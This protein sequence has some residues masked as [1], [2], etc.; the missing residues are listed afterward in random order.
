MKIFNHE[1]KSRNIDS[2]NPTN[3]ID[4]IEHILI[5]AVV[6]HRKRLSGG[7]NTVEEVTLEGGVRAIFKPG[8]GERC[9]EIEES[10][11]SL[12][13]RERAAFLVSQFLGFD[14]VPPTVV[15][16][17]HGSQGSL[18]LFVNG[19]PLR[20]IPTALSKQMYTIALFDYLIWNKDRKGDNLLH[21][22]SILV[23]IDNG[24]SF[25]DW[26]ENLITRNLDEY[27]FNQQPNNL[28]LQ[29][30]SKFSQSTQIKN[31]LQLELLKLL[32]KKAV[33]AFF[34]RLNLVIQKL[35]D[36]GVIVQTDVV[37]GDR[38]WGSNLR[39]DK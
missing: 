38:Y 9:L 7:S 26:F 35:L 16:T 30:L 11:H 36:N 21:S 19:E 18:Q 15:R 32:P 31:E 14:I 8:V 17:I 4:N 24:L 39:Y 27:V 20:S 34:F 33:D 6:L 25:D 13:M 23:P 10:C 5:N 28:V 1:A 2:L 37:L 22:S 29:A 3:P 12:F